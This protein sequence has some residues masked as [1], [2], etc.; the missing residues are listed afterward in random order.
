MEFF[1]MWQY[2]KHWQ[3]PLGIVGWIIILNRKVDFCYL[4]PKLSAL[5]HFQTYSIVSCVIV[6][7]FGRVQYIFP[8]FSRSVQIARCLRHWSCNHCNVQIQQSGL[9]PKWVLWRMAQ[10]IPGTTLTIPSP[11]SLC[12]HQYFCAFYL[13]NPINNH[14]P[15][16]TK[17]KK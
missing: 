15:T 4:C 10:L 17:W 13:P 9:N 6:S 3:A 7:A 2:W 1:L 8:S 11:A 12:A 14:F 5:E 16:F